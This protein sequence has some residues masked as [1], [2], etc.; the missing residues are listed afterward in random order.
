M[1]KNTIQ[2]GDII[3]SLGGFEAKIR[4]EKGTSALI[5]EENQENQ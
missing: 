2:R 1:V 5:K 4:E 3:V